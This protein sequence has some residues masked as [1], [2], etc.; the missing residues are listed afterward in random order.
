ME[1]IH[2]FHFVN[3]IVTI[4]HYSDI[5]ISVMASEIPSISTVCSNVCSG[6]L[7]IK[8]QSPVSLAVVRGNLPVTGG[9]P[10]QRAS[11]TENISICWRHPGMGGCHGDNFWYLQWQQN[12]QHDKSS[13]FS[14]RTLRCDWNIH[15]ASCMTYNFFKTYF[16]VLH[17]SYLDVN[18]PQIYVFDCSLHQKHNCVWYE[19]QYMLLRHWS[20][21]KNAA[22]LQMPF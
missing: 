13:R 15:G 7:H 20:W 3:F 10:S 11:G 1:D 6:A 4:S 21:D 5:T 8:H 17:L 22:V 19:L 14:V 2:R 18:N 16:S 12:S 9:F